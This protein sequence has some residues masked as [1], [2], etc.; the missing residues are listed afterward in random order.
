MDWLE[1]VTKEQF[2]KLKKDVNKLPDKVQIKEFKNSS[3]SEIYEKDLDT[4]LQQFKDDYDFILENPLRRRNTYREKFLNFIEDD[5][6]YVF[7]MIILKK[8][9]IIM[10]QV[11]KTCQS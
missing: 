1:Y 5:E 10:Q 2:R 11:V 9:E 8:E 6:Y 3:K 7:G 4:F